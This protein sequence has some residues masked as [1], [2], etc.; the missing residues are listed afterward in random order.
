MFQ[1]LLQAGFE[2]AFESRR[3]ALLPQDVYTFFTHTMEKFR[4]LGR[5]KISPSLL[6]L[7]QVENRR[8]LLKQKEACWKLVLILPILTQ[9]KWTMPYLP[10]LNLVIILSVNRARYWF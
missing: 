3:P 10:Y 1:N 4:S 2:A 5:V 6:A 9:Q 8:S 7:Y